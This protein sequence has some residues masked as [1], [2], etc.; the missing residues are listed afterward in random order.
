M[1]Q[2][3]LTDGGDGGYEGEWAANGQ[4]LMASAASSRPVGLCIAYWHMTKG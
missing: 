2:I 4:W 3:G 1:G